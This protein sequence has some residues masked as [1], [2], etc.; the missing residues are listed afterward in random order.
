MISACVLAIVGLLVAKEPIVRAVADQVP[1]SLEVKLGKTVFAQLDQGD[2]FL[3]GSEL[4]GSLAR[5]TEPLLADPLR[6]RPHSPRP[7]PR[8][9]CVAPLRT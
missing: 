9:L 5:L 6:P 1:A 4:E 7:R 3:E 2:G 8:A